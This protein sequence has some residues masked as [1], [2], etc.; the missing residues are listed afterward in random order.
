MDITTASGGTNLCNGQNNGANAVAAGNGITCLASAGVLYSFDFDG[1]YS[2]SFQDYFI[3]RIG[4]TD[5]TGNEFWGILLDFAFTAN[6]GCETEP[7]VGS[8]LLWAFN[9]FNANSFLDVQPR[10]ATVVAGGYL[11]SF[12][13]LI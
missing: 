1:T 9:A 12:I 5:Q 8:E 11:A 10:T 7:P 3:E 4:D 2:A 6:G 13:V